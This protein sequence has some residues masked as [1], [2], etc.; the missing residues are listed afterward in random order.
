MSSAQRKVTVGFSI[1][2]GLAMTWGLCTYTYYW[3]EDLHAPAGS[4]AEAAFLAGLPVLELATMVSVT[5]R[6]CSAICYVWLGNRSGEREAASTQRANNRW[7]AIEGAVWAVFI[8]FY[9]VAVVRS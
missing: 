5:L 2:I 8:T 6:I 7:L 9:L 4:I 3:Y 1:A